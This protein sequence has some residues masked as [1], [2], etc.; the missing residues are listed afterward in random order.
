M[1]VTVM[2]QAITKT[3]G[4]RRGVV[5]LSAIPYSG[6]GCLLT[7]PGVTLATVGRPGQVPDADIRLDRDAAIQLAYGLLTSIGAYGD[8]H[9]A[10]ARDA[11]G[12]LLTA[13]S[14]R[15]PR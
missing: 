3:K 8:S 10:A 13:P 4:L 1:S 14:E 12:E 5:Y 15:H 7:P 11:L 6:S 2:A 9:V